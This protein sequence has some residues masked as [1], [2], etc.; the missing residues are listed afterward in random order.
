MGT[1]R[2]MSEPDAGPPTAEECMTITQRAEGA[3]VVVQVEGEVDTLTAPRLLA[4]L[5]VALHSAVARQVIADLRGVTF[6]GSAGLRALVRAT[7]QAE[8]Q[9]EPLRIV[10]DQNRPVVLPIQVTG[11]DQVLALYHSLSD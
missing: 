1:V 8:R 3:A 10:V 11:L 7:E 2:R 9:H 5:E 4:A 6:L